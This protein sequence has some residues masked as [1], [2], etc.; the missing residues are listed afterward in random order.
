MSYLSGSPC[1]C[2]KA[3]EFVVDGYVFIDHAAPWSNRPTTIAKESHVALPTAGS[4]QGGHGLLS[5]SHQITLHT[6]GQ[7]SEP[8]GRSCWQQTNINPILLSARSALH[9]GSKACRVCG[10]QCSLQLPCKGHVLDLGACCHGCFAAVPGPSWGSAWRTTNPVP[11]VLQSG[12]QRPHGLCSTAL[13]ECCIG[14]CSAVQLVCTSAVQRRGMLRAGAC[15]VQCR[16]MS[17]ARACYVLWQVLCRGM[18][19]AAAPAGAC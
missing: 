1:S 12:A 9:S 6:P 2:W 10:H 8:V 15:L 3:S 5:K 16:D 11:L 4:V 13:Q 14:Q 7:P 19:R 17:S 18:L